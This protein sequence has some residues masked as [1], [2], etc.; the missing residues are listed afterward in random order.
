M[1]SLISGAGRLNERIMLNIIAATAVYFDLSPAL[2]GKATQKY[3]SIVRKRVMTADQILLERW[4]YC[5]SL[6]RMS[7]V[8]MYVQS[9]KKNISKVSVLASQDGKLSANTLKWNLHPQ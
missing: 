4:K 1:S 2:N 7:I 9:G 5:V 3:L 6:Q 8:S